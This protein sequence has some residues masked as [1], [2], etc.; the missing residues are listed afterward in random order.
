MALVSILLAI[1]SYL[2]SLLFVA[3]VPSYDGITSWSS[4]GNLVP[5]MS[6]LE[7]LGPNTRTGAPDEV[8]FYLSID[9]PH[10]EHQRRDISSQA[11]HPGN[12]YTQANR[13]T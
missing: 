8:P 13:G 11:T 9:G 3:A 10:G 4:I 7:G 6:L 1:A 2:T 5:G 12:L